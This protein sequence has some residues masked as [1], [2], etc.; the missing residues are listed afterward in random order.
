MKSK[1]FF[2][3]L[4]VAVLLVPSYVK[5][6][7]VLVEWVQTYIHDNDQGTDLA[8]DSSGNVYVTG[9]FNRGSW[10]WASPKKGG[11]T[12]VKY[13]PNGSMLWAKNY[14]TG[15][16]QTG[17]VAIKA[18]SQG[19]AYITGNSATIKYDSDGNELWFRSGGNSIAVDSLG[20]AYVT[21]G[22]GTAKYDTNGNELWL[23]GSGGSAIIVDP[24]GNVYVTGGNGTIKYD[25]NGNELWV[26][27]GGNA[28]A[29]DLPGNVYVSDGS[30]ITKYD[31]N[32]NELYLII[33][34]GI[35]AVDLTGNVYVGR[36]DSDNYLITKYDSQGNISWSKRYDSGFVDRVLAITV[37]LSGN[38]YLT[39]WVYFQRSS[40]YGYRVLGSATVK[41]DANGNELWS[42]VYQY[43]YGQTGT[44]VTNSIIADSQGNVYISGYC[45][46]GWGYTSY[47]TIKLKE[48]AQGPTIVINEPQ[49]IWPPNS[50]TVNVSLTGTITDSGSGV[51]TASYAVNDEYGEIAPSGNISLASDGGFNLNIPLEAYRKGSDLD[52]RVYT[53]NITAMDKVGNTSSASTQTKVLHN[54]Q[55]K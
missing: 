2:L 52:G 7:G 9:F 49:S 23:R 43:Q 38:A 51:A 37:D 24:M 13:T 19:N 16:S 30:N 45:H 28:I 4:I 6:E 3:F 15:E 21:G 14:T 11:Y 32:G 44:A 53:I 8:L 17:H 35:M 54:Q 29:L 40:F 25:T 18:D 27:S 20:N 10:W 41:Y 47:L 36:T 33:D 48:D 1:K 31:E 55:E 12:T 22:N 39:G 42:K 5:A 26:R 50:K 46:A 34:S